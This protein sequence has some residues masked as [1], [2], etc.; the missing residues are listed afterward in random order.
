[1]MNVAAQ[2]SVRVLYFGP[3]REVAGAGEESFQVA[4]GTSVD[5]LFELCSA[6][7][8]GL[9]NYR[10]AAAPSRNCEF[11]AWS[12]DLAEGDEIAF[13]PPVSGG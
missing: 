12:S 4:A 3:L 13:L 11:A 9:A 2:I 6:R 7:H 5:Q 8:P 10:T 1:M